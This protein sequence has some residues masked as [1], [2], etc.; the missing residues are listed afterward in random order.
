[1]VGLGKTAAYIFVF[2]YLHCGVELNRLFTWKS[3]SL[4]NA[5]K[6]DQFFTVDISFQNFRSNMLPQ[7]SFGD[8]PREGWQ[9][10]SHAK[11]PHLIYDFK[12]RKG[13]V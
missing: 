8:V 6:I 9:H 5:G 13:K 1:M 2:M 10:R 4:L 12:L 11:G 7:D 3:A